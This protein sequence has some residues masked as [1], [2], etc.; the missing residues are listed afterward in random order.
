MNSGNES[1]PYR[2]TLKPLVRSRHF[3]FRDKERRRE[4]L[5][6]NVAAKGHR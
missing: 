2:W 4:R 1:T 3:A 5:R 6:A